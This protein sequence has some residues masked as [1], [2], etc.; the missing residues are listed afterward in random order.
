MTEAGFR[1]QVRH[2]KQRGVFQVPRDSQQT[3]GAVMLQTVNVGFGTQETH[4][5]LL[6]AGL[7]VIVPVSPPQLT[8][9]VTGK[10]HI[11]TH[12]QAV[13][14]TSHLSARGALRQIKQHAVTVQKEKESTIIGINIRCT[15]NLQ[16][17]VLKVSE[18]ALEVPN[19]TGAWV[20][21]GM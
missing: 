5:E 21:A 7:D 4:A 18:V 11:T 20:H 13:T 9:F 3:S 14:Q 8:Q 10:Q 1:Q 12:Q 6:N 17:R 19:H 15:I 16:E 2:R